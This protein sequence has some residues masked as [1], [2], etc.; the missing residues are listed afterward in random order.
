MEAFRDLLRLRRGARPGEPEDDGDPVREAIGQLYREH[1]EAMVGL[2]IALGLPPEDAQNLAHETF[3]RVLRSGKEEVGRKYLLQAMRNAV[4]NRFRDRTR[5]AAR[6]EVYDARVRAEGHPDPRADQDVTIYA[7]GLDGKVEALPEPGRTV[8]R[9]CHVL[10]WKTPTVG[11]LMGMTPKAVS[12][13]GDRARKALAVENQH[14]EG[15]RATG[16]G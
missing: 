6:H 11:P 4:K 2:G 5:E 14:G 12:R 16:T 7:D 1:I 13:A 15:D 9:L 3:L 10:G 8:L